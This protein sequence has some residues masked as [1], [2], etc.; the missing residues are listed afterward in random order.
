MVTK[1]CSHYNNYC[2]VEEL[3][4]HIYVFALDVIYV[5]NTG[6]TGYVTVLLLFTTVLAHQMMQVGQRSYIA[7]YNSVG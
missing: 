4:F 1:N 6:L 3:G 5:F 7:T 2:N